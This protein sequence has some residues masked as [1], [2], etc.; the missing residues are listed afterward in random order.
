MDH[1]QIYLAWTLKPELAR[2][3]IMARLTPHL[4]VLHKKMPQYWQPITCDTM[5][6]KAIVDP[7]MKDGK[8]M[9]GI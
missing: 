8:Q 9:T 2:Y 7:L 1:R 4:R 6:H 5:C 3:L